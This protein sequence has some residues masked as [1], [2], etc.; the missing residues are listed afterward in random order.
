MRDEGLK[1]KTK[2]CVVLRTRVEDEMNELCRGD[3]VMAG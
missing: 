2:A 3:G 1:L